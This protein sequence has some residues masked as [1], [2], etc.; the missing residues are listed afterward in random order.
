MSVLKYNF[1]VGYIS[2]TQH[3]NITTSGKGFEYLRMLYFRRLEDLEVE[4]YRGELLLQTVTSSGI[5]GNN[6]HNVLTRQ[7]Q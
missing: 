3:D 6:I 4:C 1:A 5:E 7:S 2:A